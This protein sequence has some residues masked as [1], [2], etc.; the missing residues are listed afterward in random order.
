MDDGEL[1]PEAAPSAQAATAAAG[2][3]ARFGQTAAPGA[4]AAGWTVDL[5]EMLVHD[6]HLTFREAIRF[7]MSA[8]RAILPARAARLGQSGPGAGDKAEGR[9]RVR[10][11]QWLE[12]HFSIL[13]DAEFSALAVPSGPRG[14]A[15]GDAS[16]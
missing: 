3:L 15:A 10:A 12:A 14:F 8:A 1:G 2:D 11:R 16:R 6:Y 5:L 13:P 4:S 9:A 7:P